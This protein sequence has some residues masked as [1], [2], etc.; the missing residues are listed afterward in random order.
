MVVC[1]THN[2]GAKVSISFDTAKGIGKKMRPASR[3]KGAI[4]AI[5]KYGEGISPRR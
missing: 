1:S 5:I 4:E 3:R 2:H